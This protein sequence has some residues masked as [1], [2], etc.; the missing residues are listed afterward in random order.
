MPLTLAWSSLQNRAQWFTWKKCAPVAR[1][2]RSETFRTFVTPWTLLVAYVR[3][4]DIFPG[5]AYQLDME[6]SGGKNLNATINNLMGPPHAVLLDKS[7]LAYNYLNWTLFFI[8]KGRAKTLKLR[9]RHCLDQCYFMT[10]LTGDINLN[11]DLS[12]IAGF[13]ILKGITSAEV[14][15]SI[16][17]IT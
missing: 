12:D 1:L 16:V 8:V 14:T 11:S 6:W 7:T 15:V 13:T 9:Y 5:K 2:A 3:N 10:I 17:V 4:W